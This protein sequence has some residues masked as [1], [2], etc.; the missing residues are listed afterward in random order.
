MPCTLFTKVVDAAA[1]SGLYDVLM[2]QHG[3]PL[4]DARPSELVQAAEA[5][6]IPVVNLTTNVILLDEPAVRALI[7]AGLDGRLV[8]FSGITR[9]AGAARRVLSEAGQKK[10]AGRTAGRTA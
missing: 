5:C 7:G 4:T 3:G 6:G 9:A 1:G 2:H 10:R 8:L